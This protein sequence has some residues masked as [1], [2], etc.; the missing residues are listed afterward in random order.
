LESVDEPLGG[1]PETVTKISGALETAEI[2][3]DIK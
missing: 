2:E 1:E 3:N